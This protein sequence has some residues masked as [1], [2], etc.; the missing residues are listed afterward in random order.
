MSGEGLEEWTKLG[1]PSQETTVGWGT[2]PA[3]PLLTPLYLWVQSRLATG[4]LCFIPSGPSQATT[5]GTA[6][7]QPLASVLSNAAERSSL[8]SLDVTAGGTDPV[9]TT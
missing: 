1:M 4:H 5:L 9:G 3:G 2:L 8:V 7:F 6:A